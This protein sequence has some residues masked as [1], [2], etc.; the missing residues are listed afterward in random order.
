MS[1]AVGFNGPKSIFQIPSSFLNSI[2]TNLILSE[3]KT[4]I[5][6]LAF[7]NF[8]SEDLNLLEKSI[9]GRY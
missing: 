4:K 8:K 7:K 1:K 3:Y 2:S 9:L 6:P 5:C